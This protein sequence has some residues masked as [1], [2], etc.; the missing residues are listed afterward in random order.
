VNHGRGVV[1]GLDRPMPEGEEPPGAPEEED[2]EDER[3]GADRFRHQHPRA[4]GFGTSQGGRERV[5]SSVDQVR[6]VD[7]LLSQR[8]GSSPGELA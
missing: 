7:A 2:V 3:E 8:G 4:W 1:A 6:R 5:E